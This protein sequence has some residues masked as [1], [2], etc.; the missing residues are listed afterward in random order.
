M[1]SG[2]GEDNSW[3]SRAKGSETRAAE[4]SLWPESGRLGPFVFVR[5]LGSGG[6]APVWLAEEVYNRTVLRQA[7][8]KLF[9]VRPEVITEGRAEGADGQPSTIHRSI[10]A[11]A[12]ALCRVEHPNVVRFY[13]LAGDD[14]T[15]GVIGLA[16]EYVDG[17]SLAE[18]LRERGRLS[19]AETVSIGLAVASALAAV[20]KVGLVHRD[21]KPANI[22]ESDGVCKL[23]DF[24]LATAESA[25][26]AE[27]RPMLRLQ[28]A[29][30]TQAQA[31]A[32]QQHSP[33][34]HLSA[35]DGLV[36][37]DERGGQ[38][39]VTLATKCGTLGYMDPNCMATGSPAVPA[40]DLYALGVILFECLVGFTPSVTDP[41][42][43]NMRLGLKSE[44]LIGHERAP[45]VSVLRPD[46]PRVLATL[47]DSMLD[48]VRS[49][50]PPSAEAVVEHLERI[51][52]ILEPPARRSFATPMGAEVKPPPRPDPGQSQ[53]PWLPPLTPPLD[54]F[55]LDAAPLVYDGVALLTRGNA[56]LVVYQAPARF[57]RTRWIFDCADRLASQWSQGIV[58]LMVVLSSADPPDARTRAEN[59]R[60]FKK[61]GNSLSAMVTVP[62]GDSLWLSLVRSIMRGINAAQG[63]SN[64]FIVAD[65]IDEGIARLVESARSDSFQRE[66]VEEGVHALCAALGVELPSRAG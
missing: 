32:P 2:G 66:Q 43:P 10:L 62:T 38:R 51:R 31:Q 1:A 14:R 5:R 40:S 56:L 4:D 41:S 15:E 18:L 26:A 45:S 11:E 54:E 17:K 53:S 24:G 60:R 63:T 36:L 52:W 55:A 59:T 19:V 65:T 27:G 9:A 13:S 6:F 12:A 46:V 22:V 39:T 49:A 33:H 34:D 7:A 61:L 20:H 28:A 47:V 50:R 30:R 58:C 42:A 21:L 48:P 64:T 25:I 8:V 23:I 44:I 57:H 16:M 35:F 3:N 37:E 29:G